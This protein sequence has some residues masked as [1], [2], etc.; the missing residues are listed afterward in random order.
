[1]MLTTV[2]SQTITGMTIR[3][4]RLFPA[5]CDKFPNDLCLLIAD[6][7]RVGAAIPCFYSPKPYHA[8]S[9][10]VT[11]LAFTNLARGRV[12]PLLPPSA[13]ATLAFETS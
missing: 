4:T 9:Q 13:Y 2:G 5:I 1:M 10:T 12:D 7:L 6:R 11:L 8:Q 3:S